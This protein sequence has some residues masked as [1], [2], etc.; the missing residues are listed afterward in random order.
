MYSYSKVDFYN[1]KPPLVDRQLNR[2]NLNSYGSTD[3]AF[4][5]LL[6]TLCLH[7][8]EDTAVTGR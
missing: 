1:A 7:T 3:I 8:I 2:N 5:K 6:K 4:F